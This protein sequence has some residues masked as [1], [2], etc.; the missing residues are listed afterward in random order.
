MF[1]KINNLRQTYDPLLPG[2]EAAVD[3]HDKCHDPKTTGSRSDDAIVPD[4]LRV[5]D[6]S[7]ALREAGFD[8]IS[9]EE[10]PDWF[11]IEWQYTDYAASVE[12]GD[13]PA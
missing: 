4:R 12:P 1:E 13:D 3:A 2:D 11:K 7:T 6:L 10:R 5:L 9:V 8:Q